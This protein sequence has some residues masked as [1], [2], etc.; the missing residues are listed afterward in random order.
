VDWNQRTVFIPPR[1]QIVRW[2]YTK[3]SGW[4]QGSD[5]GWL[6]RVVFVPETWLHMPVAPVDGPCSLYLY[7]VPGQEY[8][9]QLSTNLMEWLSLTTIVST[10]RITSYIGE[11]PVEQMSFY[12]AKANLVRPRLSISGPVPR[13]MEVSWNGDGLLESGPT[14]S[15]PWEALGGNS[16]VFF[17]A[18]VAPAQFFRVR[19]DSVPAVLGISMREAE[20]IEVSWPGLGVLESSPSLLG[21]WMDMG[22]VS[23]VHVAPEFVPAQFFRLRR[24]DQ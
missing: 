20:G 8:E 21:P 14:P 7:G 9:I 23:P 12:R 24:P 22:G 10:N 3:D 11:P 5:A 18:T 1:A 13:G 19:A 6:A 17:S 15:G 4:S 16:P 2:T